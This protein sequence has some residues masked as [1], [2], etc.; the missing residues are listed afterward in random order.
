MKYEQTKIYFDGSHY[1][2]IP[3][4]T[5]K[6]RFRPKPKAERF[7]EDGSPVKD[8]FAGGIWTELTPE[9]LMYFPEADKEPMTEQ[10]ADKAAERALSAEKK[11]V[12]PIK[13]RVTRAGEF[14]RLYEESKNRKRKDQKRF[15]L[16]NLRKFFRSDKDAEGFVEKKLQ[17]KHRALIARRIRF[18]RKA[19][20]NDFNYF[21]TV[22]YFYGHCFQ[23]GKN[24]APLPALLRFMVSK[25]AFTIIFTPN[26]VNLREVRVQGF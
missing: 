25:G 20:L 6:R 18:T 2:G 14:S 21:V 10:P 8:P 16:K 23:G 3:H 9:E 1:V 4:T 15:L 22:T 11:P 13:K 7:Y 5:V 19:Q 17:D 26:S 12:R 24:F